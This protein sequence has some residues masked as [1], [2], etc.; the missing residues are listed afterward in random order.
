MHV[1]LKSVNF[2]SHAMSI[3]AKPFVKFAT[4]SSQQTPLHV[5]AS[6]G[7]DYTVECLVKKGANVNFTD[8]AGVSIKL[9]L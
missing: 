9:Y 7:H 5:V 6:K 1:K 8:K 2:K 3:I 4:F